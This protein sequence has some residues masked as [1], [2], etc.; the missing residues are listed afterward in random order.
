MR[1]QLLP[2][3]D[4]GLLHD[5]VEELVEDTPELRPRLEAGCDQIV[6]VDGQIAKAMWA[7]ALL[8]HDLAETKERVDLV[9]RR[10]LPVAPPLPE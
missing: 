9:Q 5:C 4:A 7:R 1:E 6:A 2:G 10:R 8:L 3:V